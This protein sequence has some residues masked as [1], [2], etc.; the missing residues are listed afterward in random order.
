M[1]LAP[2]TPRAEFGKDV[3]LGYRKATVTV[4]ITD[5]FHYSEQTTECV[6]SLHGLSLRELKML[7]VAAVHVKIIQRSV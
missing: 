7:F 4:T 1:R 5:S 6:Y 3:Q 2:F